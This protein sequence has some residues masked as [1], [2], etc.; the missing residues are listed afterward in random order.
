MKEVYEHYKWWCWKNDFKDENSEDIEF[1]IS[2][3]KE[4]YKEIY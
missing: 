1:I 2:K 3:M 4:I